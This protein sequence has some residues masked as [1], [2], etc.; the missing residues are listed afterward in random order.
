MKAGVSSP[1]HSAKKY[2]DIF[3]FVQSTDDSFQVVA[4]PLTRDC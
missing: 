1:P 3:I 4:Q 2:S